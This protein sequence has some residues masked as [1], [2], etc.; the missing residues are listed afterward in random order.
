MQGKTPETIDA[1]IIGFPIEVQQRLQRLRQVILEAAPNAEETIRYQMPTFRLAGK[2]LVHFAAFQHHIGFYPIPSGIAA[3]KKE[4]S[5]Y[6]Q[7]KGSVQFPLD[8][9][10]PYELVKKIV[11]FRV[12]ETMQAIKGKK[13]R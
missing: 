13:K 3:F 6:K 11:A 4:L 9:P 12:K 5:P 8:E 7:G 1:Y 10:V 2:N